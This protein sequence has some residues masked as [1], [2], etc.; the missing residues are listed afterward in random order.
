MELGLAEL[1]AHFA[2]PEDGFA[3]VFDDHRQEE[4]TWIGEDDV[5]QVTTVPVVTFARTSPGIAWAGS[6]KEER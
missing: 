6:Q 4:I 2:L 1:V 5:R 3:T